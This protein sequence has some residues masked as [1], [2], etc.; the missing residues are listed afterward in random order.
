MFHLKEQQLDHQSTE[1]EEAAERQTK[2]EEKLV[3]QQVMIQEL[4]SRVKVR[5][6]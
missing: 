5:S 1:L 6:A 4:H 2:T 3:Q